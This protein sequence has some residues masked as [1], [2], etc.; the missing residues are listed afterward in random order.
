[1]IGLGHHERVDEALYDDFETDKAREV[2]LL[3]YLAL[4]SDLVYLYFQFYG[5]SMVSS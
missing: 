1:M 4:V 5:C 3:F 2:P